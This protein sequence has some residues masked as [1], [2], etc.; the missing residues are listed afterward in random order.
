[1]GSFRH[2]W[3]RGGSTHLPAEP[4]DC[5]SRS[6]GRHV[7]TRYVSTSS[8][9]RSPPRPP[10]GPRL[11]RCWA[12]RLVCSGWAAR[13]PRTRRRA[14]RRT[15]TAGAARDNRP[16]RPHR[17][18]CPR[19]PRPPR[20][21]V[22]RPAR[23]RAPIALRGQPAH[24][25]VVMAMEWIAA[26]RPARQTTIAL[27]YPGVPT[28]SREASTARTETPFQPVGTRVGGARRSLRAR[29]ARSRNRQPPEFLSPTINDASAHTQ[30]RFRR[31]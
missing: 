19:R 1:M 21:P 8:P 7:W 4:S 22:P 11:P 25:C 27:L 31:S 30:S 23:A 16:R 14:R 18:R 13:P 17:P 9:A 15:R 2:S 6:K 29:R 10:A 20:R 5:R 26:S 24:L 28:A 3:E 12:G